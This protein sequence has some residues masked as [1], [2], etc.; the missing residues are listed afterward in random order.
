[1]HVLR[2][3]FYVY[4]LMSNTISISDDDPTVEPR[5]LVEQYLFTLSDHE[6]TLFLLCYVFFVCLFVLVV[7]LISMSSLVMFHESLFV[8]LSFFC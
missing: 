5:T 1:M 7:L 3:L 2:G 8:F 4:I 6:F